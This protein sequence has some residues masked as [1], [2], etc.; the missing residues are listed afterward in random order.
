MNH[1]VRK[2]NVRIMSDEEFM[3]VS[4]QRGVDFFDVTFP[5]TK[6]VKFSYEKGIGTN[7]LSEDLS[8]QEFCDKFKN[9]FYDEKLKK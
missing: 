7:F 2:V 8:L 4:I 1:G 9:L 5:I 3:H 6:E